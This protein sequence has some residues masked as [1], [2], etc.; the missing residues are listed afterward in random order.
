MTIPIS[1]PPRLLLANCSSS[2]THPSRYLQLQRVAEKCPGS[3]GVPPTSSSALTAGETPALPARH[4]FP[5]L[6]MQNVVVLAMPFQQR[7]HIRTLRDHTQIRA[8]RVPH[9]LRHD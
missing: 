5:I 4:S 7:G 6:G 8:A 3:A 2:I 1:S 9:G